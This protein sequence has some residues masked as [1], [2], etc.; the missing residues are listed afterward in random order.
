MLPGG[1]V[2]DDEGLVVAGRE[3][4]VS[5]ELQVHFSQNVHTHTSIQPTV[6]FYPDYPSGCEGH[7]PH[8]PI[9]FPDRRIIK[10]KNGIFRYM[11]WAI[12]QIILFELN[13]NKCCTFGTINV[14]STLIVSGNIL[15]NRSPCAKLVKSPFSLVSLN[16]FRFRVLSYL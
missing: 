11:R 5:G 2:E 16:K 6:R 3:Q 7:S 9:N 8:I 12:R 15:T 14:E 4:L 13:R 10:I 1:T